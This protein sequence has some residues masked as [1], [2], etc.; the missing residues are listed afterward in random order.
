MKFLEKI[1]KVL[2]AC[3]VLTGCTG[4]F[5]EINTDPDSYPDAPHTNVIAYVI[6]ET[7]SRMGNDME[8]YGTFAGYIV[9]IQY[10]DYLGDLIPSNNTYGNRWGLAYRANSQFKTILDNTKEAP[11]EFRNLRLFCR[12]WQNYMWQYL[13][14]GWRDIPFSE[15][16]K[17]ADE[18]GGI[19]DA[20]YDR[21]EDVYP[22]IMANLK[23]IADEMAAGFGDDQLGEGDFIYNGDMSKWQRFCNS[24]RLRMAMRISEVSPDLAKSTIEEICGN[25]AKY[26][27]I[28]DPAYACTLT[29]P[30]AVP[31]NEPWF[32]NSRTRDDHG[33]SDIFINHLLEMNDPRIASI[34]HPAKSDGKYRGY[35]N[36]AS[37]QPAD[38]E[39]ISRIGTQY[40]DNAAG[41]TPFLKGSEAYFILAEAAMLGWSVGMTAEEA[42]EKAVRVSMQENGIA[43]AAADEYLN[44]KGKWNNTKEQIWWEM[45]VALFKDNYE[46]WA[47]YRRTGVPTTN[48]PSVGSVYGTKH[49]DQP[50][51]LPYPQNQVDFNPI[52]L[53]EPMSKCE[54]F[55]WGEQMWWDT[56]T[57]VK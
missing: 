1:S 4:K 53:A 17:G 57:G 5:D 2:L 52:G 12:L 54:D 3:L 15:A 43:D 25:S 13:T 24:L 29:W 37:S 23:E 35:L 56:R 20:K 10:M 9:K 55:A 46:A 21:Q 28:D 41:Y 22:Q 6:Q 36:G 38:I 45:W 19:V 27:F 11:E 7:G 31:Y 47:L 51:R 50:F 33:L 42:Y 48:Y 26:P 14:D 8:G 18:D 34:A 44:N 49:N 32:E 30:G 40:R 39:S 16:L